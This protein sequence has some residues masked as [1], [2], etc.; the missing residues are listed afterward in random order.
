MLL[1]ARPFYTYFM[2]KILIESSFFKL[3]LLGSISVGNLWLIRFYF[4]DK[5]NLALFYL[6]NFYITILYLFA[7]ADKLESG[8]NFIYVTGFVGILHLVKFKRNLN[9]SL[10]QF[11]QSSLWILPFII[12]IRAIPS[13]FRFTMF[14]EFP[15]WAPYIK[16]LVIEDKLAGIESA[17]R[18]L[19]EGFNQS[20]PPAQL[21]FQYLLIDKLDWQESNVIAAQII[22]LLSLVISITYLINAKGIFLRILTFI[23]LLAGYYYLGLSFG[24]IL[25]DG[26]LAVHFCATFLLA[27]KSKLNLKA[28]LLVSIAIF[29][30]ILIKPISFVFALLPM[31][32]LITR[33]ISNDLKLSQNNFQS[34]FLTKLTK[35]SLVKVFGIVFITF[36]S[37]LSWFLHVKSLEL[38]SALNTIEFKPNSYVATAKSYSSFFFAE[39]YGADNLVGNTTDLPLVFDKLNIS[40]FIVYLIAFFFS[41]LMITFISD[42]RKRIFQFG[43]FSITVFTLFFQLILIFLFTFYFGEVVAVIRYSIPILYLWVVW[44]VALAFTLL[45]KYAFNIIIKTGLIF[46]ILILLP[47]RLVADTKL[48][49]PIQS[50]LET[51]I[52][53]EK[54]ALEVKQKLQPTSK[55]YFIFQGSDGYEKY[56]FSYLILPIRSNDQCWS[57]NSPSDDSSRWNCEA[58]LSEVLKDYDYLYLGNSDISFLREYSEFFESSNDFVQNGIYKINRKSGGLILNKID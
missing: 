40:L 8:V 28:S 11:V 56:I 21:L 47:P 13:N 4:S 42:N 55:I 10:L 18:L 19:N 35:Q 44:L 30:L 46:L 29:V 5:W 53:I 38:N 31:I 39:I 22:L 52:N 50:N 32:V 26:F 16:Y 9:F 48:I 54:M 27:L 33:I 58:N 45:E 6:I 3:L 36:F 2:E 25:A 51:R 15:N 57:F 37:Y 7:L 12:F 1:L 23:S 34:Y 43:L 49:N 20:Y 17:T 41:L 24:N 14:D